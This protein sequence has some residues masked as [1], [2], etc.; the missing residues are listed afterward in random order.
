[1]ETQQSINKGLSTFLTFG[2]KSVNPEILEKLLVGRKKLVDS[3]ERNL[4]DIALNG[5]NHQA[6]LVGQRGSGKTHIL[7]V[8]YHRIQDLLEAKKLVVA[9]FTEE[10]YGIAGYLDFLIRIINAFMRWNEVDKAALEQQIDRIREM[11]SVNQVQMAEKVI[12]EY[13]GEKPLVIFCENFDEILEALG[14][15]GQSSLRAWMYRH[16]RI[17]IIATSQALSPD[18]GREDRPF[19]GFFSP[20]Y[21]KKLDYEDSLQLLQTLAEVEGRAELAD[22]LKEDKGKAKVRAIY[23]VVKGNHRLLVTFYEFLK[24]DALAALSVTFIKT[25]NDLKPYYE[26]FIRYLPPQQRKILYYLALAKLPQKGTDIAKNCFIAEKS[27]SK[28]LSELQRRNV[29]ETHPDPDDK[30]N[31]FY[32]VAE[33]LLRIAIE[34]GEQKEGITSLFIDFLALYYTV[35]DLVTQKTRFESLMNSTTDQSARQTHYYEIEARERALA[36]KN[37]GQNTNKEDDETI[38]AIRTLSGKKNYTEALKLAETVPLEKRTK[39]YFKDVGIVY[40][41]LKEYE[42]AIEYYQKAIE[43]DEKWAV[44]YFNLGIVYKNLKEYEKAIEYYQ[45]AIEMD[46]KWAVPYNN[47][48]IVYKNLK[49]YEKAIEYYQKAIEMDEK[50]A[51]PYNNLGNVYVDLKEYEKAIEYYQKAI[52]MDEK[53]AVPYNNLG[54]VYA[55]LKEYEKAIEYYQKAIE[56]DDS[57]K[58]D[59]DIIESTITELLKSKKAKESYLVELEESLREISQAGNP[60]EFIAKYV[61]VYR[62]YV[63]GKEEKALFELPKEQREFFKREILQQT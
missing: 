42:K 41:N 26:T 55:N 62:R 34:I 47:L 9:Y 52:E 40:A 61:N 8:L 63:F 48:G 45:K 38:N 13:A 32:E 18:L 44:P 23:E 36:I 39:I 53:Y 28:E 12:A 11:P 16:N 30:R 2:A 31:K 35:T 51:Y 54:I 58:N 46:E 22:Y 43:M 24:A 59:I 17:S 33:P 50:W 5:V 27:I 37:Q 15:D 60:F 56:M 29:L 21:L 10:E 7:R 49:E 6:L 14:E 20:I 25:M 19:Y 57:D 1:M 4:R 3:L